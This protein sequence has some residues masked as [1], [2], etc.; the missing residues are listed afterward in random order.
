MYAAMSEQER[1]HKILM[2]R[3]LGEGAFIVR[4]ERL[5]LVF[6][7]GQYIHVGPLPGIDR[8]EY[9]VYSGPDEDFLE[10]LV[11]EVS[12]GSVSPKLRTLEPGEMVDVEGPFGF[13]RIEPGEHFRPCLFIATGTGISPFHSL[14]LAHS[15]LDYRLVHGVRNTRELYEHESYS[16]DRLVSCVSRETDGDYHGRVTHWL[17]D[18]P[19]DPDSMVYLCGNCDMIYEVYDILGEQGIPADRIHAEVYF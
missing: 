10:I 15:E 9:S 5:G 2:I 11:K 7:A 16:A 8:R 6:D 13:F 19:A 12:A 4:F 17:K 3:E 1:K 18:H 14:T